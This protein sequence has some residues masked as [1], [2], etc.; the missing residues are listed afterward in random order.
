VV[1][2][3]LAKWAAGCDLV[4]GLAVFEEFARACRAI[5]PSS[6]EALKAWCL[7]RSL[8]A[9]ALLD[10]AKYRE[11]LLED[12]VIAGVNPFRGFERRLAECPPAD[13]ADR[14]QALRRCMHDAWRLNVLEP[15]D[16]GYVSRFGQPVHVARL[17][18][19]D[20]PPFLLAPH[21]VIRPVPAGK[22]DKA[23]PLKWRLEAPLV[24]ELIAP[25]IAPDP[26]LLEPRPENK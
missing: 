25:M 10:V 3:A 14:V 16:G 26:S 15:R 11:E 21:I 18:S 7:E 20:P 19:V 24:S 1:P 8:S 12:L 17:S 22:G 6:P 23:A 13:M 5:P 2:G 9:D 4:L